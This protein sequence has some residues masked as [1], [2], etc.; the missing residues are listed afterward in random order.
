MAAIFTTAKAVRSF[1]DA[2]LNPWAVESE[3]HPKKTPDSVN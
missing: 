1:P 2:R 3:I